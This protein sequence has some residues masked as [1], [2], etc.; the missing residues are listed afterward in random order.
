MDRLIFRRVMYFWASVIK[1][2]RSGLFALVFL[3][4]GPWKVPF[5]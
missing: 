1:I 3:A 5:F 4:F 2:N